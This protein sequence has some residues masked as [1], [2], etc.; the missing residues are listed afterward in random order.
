[1]LC[2]KKRILTLLLLSLLLTSCGVAGDADSDTQIPEFTVTT[3]AE[4]FPWL[5]SIDAE[6]W[7]GMNE[8][9]MIWSRE[10]NPDFYENATAYELADAAG[11]LEFEW[12]EK[13]SLSDEYWTLGVKPTDEVAEHIR[14][15]SHMPNLEKLE[16]DEWMRQCI[17]WDTETY[18]MTGLAYATYPGPTPNI[19]IGKGLQ[20]G[21]RAF[22]IE[23]ARIYQ[24]PEVGRYR[25]VF[26]IAIQNDSGTEYRQYYIPF[27][28]TE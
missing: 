11:V 21:I 28:V 26:Y 10:G 8:R 20:L 15:W 1:M 12:Q 24:A 4:T 18:G 23:V 27:E 19:V 16:N 6:D 3:A 14:D 22:R 25:F 13:Y 7:L 5:D 17:L 9:Y 2:Y